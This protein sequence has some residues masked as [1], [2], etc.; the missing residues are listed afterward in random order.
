MPKWLALKYYT[1]S[2]MVIMYCYNLT[3]LWVPNDAAVHQP[4]REEE[5]GYHDPTSAY[6]P[7]HAGYRR[8]NKIISQTMSTDAF[9][10]I[11]L[12]L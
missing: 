5:A 8:D 12:H 4:K 1:R 2:V 11:I 7:L 9:R 3:P 6:Y 10:I